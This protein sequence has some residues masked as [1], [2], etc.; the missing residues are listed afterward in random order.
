MNFP[1]A[2]IGLQYYHEP[3]PVM[4][5][6][7]LKSVEIKKPG[8]SVLFQTL[9][10]YKVIDKTDVFPEKGAS[11]LGFDIRIAKQ[12]KTYYQLN[13]GAEIIF[14]GGIKETIRRDGLDV[15]YKR[16]A[17][18]AGQDFLFGKA[19]F[20]QYF[21]FYIYS[22]Y[23]A[24]NAVYQKY[25]LGFRV[26]PRIVTGFYLT[27]HAHGAELMGLNVNFLLFKRP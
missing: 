3:I 1:T 18:T 4:R 16:I 22:P 23:K 26:H 12:L 20:T 8:I 7:Y 11:V 9:W 6:R 21:G 27:A 15:D 2:S 10:G 14:D 24:R 17:L 19:I 25:E 13:G 5:K